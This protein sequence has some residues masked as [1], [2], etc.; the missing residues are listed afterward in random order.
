M[1]GTPVAPLAWMDV[2]STDLKRSVD[3]YQKLFSWQLEEPMGHHGGE[4]R[5]FSHDDALV[6]GAEEIGADKGLPRW[7]VFVSTSNM[8]E[9]IA[10]VDSAGGRVTFNPQPLEQL[11]EIAMI[12]DPLGATLG[13][14]E[15]KSF[16]PANVPMVDGRFCGAE[17]T[18]SDLGVTVDFLRAALGWVAESGSYDREALFGAGTG[19]ARVKEGIQSEWVPL[20]H[21]SAIDRTL[22]T[23][24]AA[25]GTHLPPRADGVVEASDP[26]GATFFLQPA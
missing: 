20:L 12:Q 21:A 15:P 23:L 9:S 4:Y 18:T 10:R 13:V 14:W 5:L 8:D 11:G 26:M 24:L 25:G 1:N 3:F 22:E 7:T 2:V 17:L 16:D 19:R 6:A